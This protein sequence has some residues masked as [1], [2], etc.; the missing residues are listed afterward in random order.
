M[1]CDANAL[2]G[3]TTTT[4]DET[5]ILGKHGVE[6][7]KDGNCEFHL[8]NLLHP[9]GLKSMATCFE[10]CRYD[11]HTS[12]LNGACLQLDHWFVQ[13]ETQTLV[14]DAKRWNHGTDSDHAR[15]L[16]VLRLPHKTL[17]PRKIKQNMKL[18]WNFLK[19]PKKQMDFSESVDALISETESTN[20][21]IDTISSIIQKAAHFSQE[22]G[23]RKHSDWFSNNETDL[24]DAIN[25]R[26]KAYNKSTEDQSNSTLKQEL[27]ERRKVLRNLI[28][29]SKDKWLNDKARRVTNKLQLNAKG[30]DAWQA[31]KEIN[32]G[33]MGH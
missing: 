10:H 12:N 13:D 3:T 24:S 23:K 19:C 11:T 32:A 14:Q 4:D 15:V 20:L 9:H 18:Q 21:S 7:K 2:I 6:T 5:S 30:G 17:R 28:K 31:I 25:H 27:R 8:T 29:S 22:R 16:L 33:T 26:N 1:G